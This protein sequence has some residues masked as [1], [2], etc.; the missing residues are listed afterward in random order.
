MQ[1]A[2]QYRQENGYYNIN[3]MDK[4]M[5]GS[6]E[7]TRF[8]KIG[9]AFP[10]RNDSISM[11]FSALPL[12]T[13]LLLSRPFDKEGVKEG[14]AQAKNDVREKKHYNVNVVEKYTKN[15]ET[16]DRFMKVGVAFPNPGG[17]ISVILHAVPMSGR[18]LLSRAQQHNG[19]NNRGQNDNRESWGEQ[20]RAA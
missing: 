17:S 3:V 2:Q 13:R 6:E 14:K 16:K 9:A 8:T 19:S 20:K 1:T 7:K 12:S 18:L 11:V 10:N 4:Y 5:K 15:G